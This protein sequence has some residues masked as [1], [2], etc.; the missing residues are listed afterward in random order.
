MTSARGQGRANVGTLVHVDGLGPWPD[1][2]LGS[3]L[4]PKLGHWTSTDRFRKMILENKDTQDQT[5][6]IQC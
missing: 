1:G 3:G 2:S 6:D 4:G 5:N